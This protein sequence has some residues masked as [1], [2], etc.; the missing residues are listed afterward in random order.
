VNIPMHTYIH[1]YNEKRINNEGQ[2]T[3]GKYNHDDRS[4]L[5]KR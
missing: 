5:K 1:M 2:G 4:D 3:K